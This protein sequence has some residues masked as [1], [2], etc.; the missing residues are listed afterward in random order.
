MISLVNSIDR[1]QPISV[2][3]GTAK[4]EMLRKRYDEW[5]N[6]GKQAMMSTNPFA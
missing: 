4:Q 1:A 6:I 2:Y 3:K 5:V